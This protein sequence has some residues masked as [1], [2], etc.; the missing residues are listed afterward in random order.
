MTDRAPLAFVD[1]AAQYHA[2][3]PEIDAAI[4]RVLDHGRFIMGPEVAELEEKLAAFAGCGHAVTVSSGT[5]AL[6]IALMAEGVGPGDAVFLPAFTF[7][8]TAEVVV[9]IGA[10]PVFV[11]VHENS[12]NI[13]R[14]DLETR[15]QQVLRN[16][17][18]RPRAVIAVDLFGLPAKYDSLTK[19]VEEHDL[20]V[21]ADGAQ[22]FGARI[23][24][25]RVGTLAPA[26]A[27]SFFPAKPLGCYGDGGAIL[28]DDPERAALYRSIRL[29]GKGAAKYDI[30]RIGVNGRL[31]TIQA[32]VLLAKL[33]VF[34]AELAARERL[35]RLYDQRLA[36]VVKTPH[37]V[38]TVN[39]A[40]AQYTVR[41]DN[42]DAVQQ[43]LKEQGIPTAVYYPRPMHLQPAYERYGD[44]AGSL[45]VSEHLCGEVLS[46]PMHPFLTDADITRIAAAVAAALAD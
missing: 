34:A 23:G 26:T 38:E 27:V 45:P 43:R 14:R 40:W 25:R 20:F 17:T 33:A 41:V 1:L 4:Q 5:D 37:R 16:G 22:S 31:D 42:R 7:T 8:A 6:L 12:F 29:H 10:T 13:S 15:I 11:D 46:L 19:V 3:Q 39:S 21:L 2:L 36:G 30:A 18:L 9:N 35:S 28:T 24:D 44:S 32:A